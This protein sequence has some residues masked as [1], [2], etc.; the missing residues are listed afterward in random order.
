MCLVDSEGGGEDWTVGQRLV[1][2]A[3]G[4][5]GSGEDVRV[6]GLQRDSQRRR[7]RTLTS[8]MSDMTEKTQ[9]DWRFRG[10][11]AIGELLSCVRAS[12]EELV[13]CRWSAIWHTSFNL[14]SAE[15]C[16]M[17]TLQ[18]HRAARQSPR[19]LD[20][21]RLPLVT[22]S[23]LVAAGKVLTGDLAKWTGEEQKAEASTLKQQ[24]LCADE[25]QPKREKEKGQRQP[26]QK[27]P[28]EK[29]SKVV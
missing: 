20:F 15:V 11:R 3:Q 19:N 25:T 14:A 6:L 27:G 17:T 8:A 22:D 5:Q 26:Q 28:E 2:S 7:F 23:Q 21:R 10:P 16:A 9:T 4:I 18:I 1:A 24:R 12:G 13:S 29:K